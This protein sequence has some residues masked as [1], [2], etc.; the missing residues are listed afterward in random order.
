L[1]DCARYL[2]V[3]L[4]TLGRSRAVFE[5]LLQE[6]SRQALDQERLHTVRARRGRLCLRVRGQWKPGFLV[7]GWDE[8][9]GF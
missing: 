1:T 9:L 4:A 6:A 2:K 5:E 8:G 3:K 7:R